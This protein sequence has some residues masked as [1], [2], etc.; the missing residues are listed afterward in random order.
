MAVAKK[1]AIVDLQSLKIEKMIIRIDGVTPLITHVFSQK[2][3]QKILD[4]QQKK[5][6]PVKYDIKNPVE[7]FIESLYWLEGKP[8]EYTEEA[9]EEALMGGARFGFPS[10]GLKAS[11]VSAGYRAGVCKDKVSTNGFFHIDDEFIEIHGVPHMREDAV[12]V[13]M[14]TD[15]RF[16]GQFDEWHSYALIKY[17]A[18]AI[19]PEQIIN[20][21]MLGGFAV[22]I[23][24]WRPEK[25]GSFGMYSVGEEKIG[26]A[27]K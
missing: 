16:R 22:G 4:K 6:S 26:K 9:F 23:G 7:D 12:P 15:I 27:K 3:K 24:E 18:G 21:F 5:A 1:A 14:G 8:T 19:S 25:S 2:A 13:G 20:L 10:R 17:N 11:A